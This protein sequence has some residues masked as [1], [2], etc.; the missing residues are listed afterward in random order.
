MTDSVLPPEDPHGD[1]AWQEA[2][3]RRKLGRS[4]IFDEL[5]EWRPATS[6]A[7]P[8]DPAEPAA[9]K[10]AGEEELK[11][12]DV[13]IPRIVGKV[14]RWVPIGL[15]EDCPVTCLGKNGRTYFYLSPLGELIAL[16]DAEHGQAHIRGL[17]SPKL[18][19]LR[20]A[21]PQ[22]N[23]N[24][25]HKG[26]AAQY[27]ADALTTACGAKGIFEAHDR[28]RGLG[29]WKGE[30]GALIQ[31][32]GDR[33]L[34]GET[35]HKPGEIDGY[36]YPGRPSMPPGKA[37]RTKVSQVYD[38]FQTWNW[39]RGEL[40]ARLLLGQ[41]ASTVLGAALDWRPM[42]FVC[43]D[44]ATGKSTLQRWVRRMLPRRLVGTVD[45]SEAA[46][47]GL[48]GQDA[49]GVSF[50]EIEA[51]AS[52][53]KAQQVM[54]LAR[55]AASGDDAYRSSASQDL[56]QFTLR[57]SFLFSAIIPPSMRPQDMQRFA[58]LMLRPLAKDAKLPPLSAGDDREL[59]AALVGRITAAWDRWEATLDAF[60]LGLAR[61]GHAQRGA[62]QFGTLLAAAHLVLEDRP[63]NEVDI[64]TWC[65]QLRRESLFE[66]QNAEPVW[67]KALRRVLSAQP[68]IWRAH[69]FPTVAEV[70]RKYLLGLKLNNKEEM[71]V[72]QK[73]LTRAGLAIVG[74]KGTTRKYLA[75]PPRHPQVGAIF[76]GT[77]FQAA[78]GGDGAW[79]IPL[80]SAP[81]IEGAE[82]ERRGVWR[83]EK[84]PRLGRDFRCDLFWL[85]G[86]AEIGGV[87][88][89][90]FDATVDV[91]DIEPETERE[92]GE[93]G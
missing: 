18:R 73:R 13:R 22:L 62:I 3:R 31:H 45:A 67:L 53:E 37:D 40:D 4:A 58:F 65:G 77:D 60:A 43:G 93:E 11:F 15:P 10:Y 91:D 6:P 89:P 19:E 80:A 79:H 51:D 34:V 29:C 64:A 33:V 5:E 48:L 61:E 28:V 20:Q 81:K 86:R 68:E 78:G 44:A 25:T 84:V 2:Q 63:P 14:L 7:K 87:W 24:G 59:G 82:T 56:K 49:V 88:T 75:I 21:F 54:K 71:D 90:I 92:P 74:E 76:K 23:Q 35:E 17:W 55:T 27:A 32:L 46:L 83:S 9:D 52:N 70:I 8:G 1:R 66:Y 85:D 36:V 47:R 72:A 50:D 38:R 41:L 57:G 12:D 26:F 39:S 42:A 69:E 16:T 30:D